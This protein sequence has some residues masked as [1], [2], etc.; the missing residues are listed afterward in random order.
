MNENL[1]TT[2]GA[3]RRQTAF[4]IDGS[5]GNDSQFEARLNF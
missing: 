4:E 2:A 1:F 5:N 3:G